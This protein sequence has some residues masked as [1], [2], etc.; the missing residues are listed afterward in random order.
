M[1]REGQQVVEIVEVLQPYGFVAAKVA[2]DN[3][4]AFGIGTL[5]KHHAGR[6]AR[7]DVEQEE[8]KGYHSQQYQESIKEPF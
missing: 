4:D 2:V 8:D 3:L 7:Q 1:E 6:V 5:A